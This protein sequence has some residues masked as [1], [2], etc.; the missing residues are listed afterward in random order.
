[1][2]DMNDKKTTQVPHE[3][4]LLL[5]ESDAGSHLWCDDPCPTGDPDNHEV[6]KYYHE[7]AV[8]KI[9]ADLQI[10]IMRCRNEI[11]RLRAILNQIAWLPTYDA[12]GS[13]ASLIAAKALMEQPER[14]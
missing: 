5:G 9:E 6:V 14:K 8:K 4:Y 12:S 3:I 11:M 10:E 2:S 7:D 13:R 1:M